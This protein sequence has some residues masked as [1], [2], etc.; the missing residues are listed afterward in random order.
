MKESNIKNVKNTESSKLYL[1][2]DCIHITKSI[3][4]K[5]KEIAF[6]LGKYIVISKLFSKCSYILFLHLK[7]NRKF[8]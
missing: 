5:K 7:N 2:Q 6:L 4:D 8:K 1:L 3:S